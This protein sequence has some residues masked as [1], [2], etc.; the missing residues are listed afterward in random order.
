MFEVRKT[1][2]GWG[3]Y[4]LSKRTWKSYDTTNGKAQKQL[5]ILNKYM[6]TSKKNGAG[7]KIML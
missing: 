7:Y 4:N 1:P 3:V 2:K 6:Y 5:I